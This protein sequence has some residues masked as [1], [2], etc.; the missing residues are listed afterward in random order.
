MASSAKK[1]VKTTRDA[2]DWLNVDYKLKILGVNDIDKQNNE[3][4]I[5]DINVQAFNM[6]Q[7]NRESNRSKTSQH[8]EA[9]TLP[10]RN[11]ANRDFILDKLAANPP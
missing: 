5:F 1:R 10:H 2:S 11:P 6:A 8:E 9:P 4:G 7:S 3:P